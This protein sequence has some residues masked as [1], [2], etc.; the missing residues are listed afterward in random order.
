MIKVLLIDDEYLFRK[1]LR[2][3]IP[4][5]ELGFSICGEAKNGEEALEMVDELKPDVAL[6]DINMPIIDGIGFIEEIRDR[7]WQLEIIIITGYSEFHYAKQAISLGVRNYILKPVEE[8]ELEKELLKIKSK[9]ENDSKLNIRIDTL[10][11]QVRESIPI[12]R[13]KFLNELIYRRIPLDRDTILNRLG[14]LNIGL[15]GC[16]YRV[17]VIERDN[18]SKTEYDGE[19]ET[20]WGFAISNIAREILSE[21]CSVETCTDNENRSCVLISYQ[22]DNRQAFDF[23]TTNLCERIRESV[24]RYLKFTVT[25]GVG[26]IYDSITDIQTSYMEAVFSINN[27]VIEGC[28]KVISYEEIA[29]SGHGFNV[30]TLEHRQRLLISMRIVDRAEI[31]RSIDTVFD[32][33]KSNSAPYESFVATCIDLISTCFEFAT[34]AGVKIGDIFTKTFNLF[35]EIYDKKSYEELKSWVKGVML[36]V[37]EAAAASRKTRTKTLISD[38]KRYLYDNL[39]DTELKV[40]N[41]SKHLFINYS[42]LSHTF[43]KETGQ[44]VSEFLTGI[45]VARAKE[46]IDGGNHSIYVVSE[47]SGYID[48][49]YFSRCFKKYYGMTP[50]RYM[51]RVG[52]K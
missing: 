44:T 41:I 26:G 23:I 28:N 1:A 27:K 43:K 12:L 9:L 49:N 34:E 48:P 6:V 52:T 33:L 21:A 3:K 35:N 10:K 37:V 2:V 8:K 45:R 20:L 50:T 30:Y 39:S 5:E 18:I 14:Y 36:K 25:I 7:G 38:I 13:E 47:N 16:L 22:D 4:W 19:E 24:E 46:L 31:E 15:N 29:E 17:A 40:E 11:K 32:T 42:Y 51:E